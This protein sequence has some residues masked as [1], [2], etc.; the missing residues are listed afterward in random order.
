MAGLLTLETKPHHFKSCSAG[1]E[2]KALQR[3]LK[4]EIKKGLIYILLVIVDKDIGDAVDDNAKGS[5]FSL[6]LSRK[7]VRNNELAPL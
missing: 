5:R 1:P 2:Y 7:F 3:H 6:L 4:F